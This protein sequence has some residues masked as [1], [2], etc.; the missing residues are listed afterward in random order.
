[1]RFVRSRKVG[2][3][4]CAD[5]LPDAKLTYVRQG[6]LPPLKEILPQSSYRLPLKFDMAL[7]AVL[8]EMLVLGSLVQGS[9]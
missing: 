5:R 9:G 8:L 6:F 7:R 1:M 4:E 2:S 3:T